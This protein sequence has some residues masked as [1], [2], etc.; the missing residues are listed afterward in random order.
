M[1]RAL[2]V[3]GFV[4]GCVVNGPA[5]LYDASV[6]DIA[7]PPN[8]CDTPRTGTCTRGDSCSSFEFGC[9]CPAGNWVCG[10]PG[11]FAPKSC[12]AIWD[13]VFNQNK[14]LNLCEAG[15][16]Q[17]AKDAFALAYDCM[18]VT[19][20]GDTGDASAGQECAAGNMTTDAGLVSC[21]NCINNT[22]NGPMSLFVDNNGQHPPCVPT[23]AAECGQCVNAALACLNQ[24]FTDADCN[25]F[26][27]PLTCIGASGVTPGTCG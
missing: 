5:P 15:K 4:A 21:N 7:F 13:C 1:G 12:I 27:T 23:T 19:Y 18:F 2:M 24:C 25:S 16:P 14:P 17:V 8:Y 6:R 11:D 26:T 22:V 3:L 10:S 20:C 9:Y